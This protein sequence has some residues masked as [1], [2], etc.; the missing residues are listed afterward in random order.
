M[1]AVLDARRRDLDRLAS[2][3]WELLVVGGGITGSGIALDAASRG[4]RTALVEREDHAVGT[5]GRSSR[6]IHGGLRYLEQLRIGLVREA[7]AERRRLLRLA[8]HLV[9]IE[10]FV[11]PLYGGPLTRPF[12]EA[13]LTLYDLLGAAADGGWH[14]HL[15]VDEALETTPVLRRQRL[16]G[17]LVYHDGQEDD[18]RYTLAVART[19]RVRGAVPVTRLT[20][21][22]AIEAGGRIAGVTVR[23]ELGG[24]EFDV[25]AERVVDATGVWSGRPEGPFPWTGSGPAVRPSRGTHIVVPRDRIPSAHGLTLRIPGR[26][27]FLVPWPDRWVIGTTDIDDD[28]PP[29]HPVPSAAEVDAILTNVNATLDID[30]DR[31]DVVGAYTGLRPLASDPGGHPGSTV[32]A[33]REHRIRTDPNGLVRI[34]GGKYTTYRLMAA[35]TVDVAV[36][37]ELAA[38]RPSQTAELPL[39][40]AAPIAE[41]DAL[42]ARLTSEADLDPDRAARLVARH[43]TE[44][45]AVVALG[46]ELDLLRPLGP[47][48]AHLEVEAVWAVR[49]EVALSLDDVLSRRTRLSQELAD[50][51]AA[52]APRVAELI[53]PELGWSEAD[54]APA[55]EA[56][57]ASAHTEYDVP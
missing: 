13:G 31:S 10:P 47:D 25:L 34:G 38:Q 54:R 55:V 5:S 24:N 15:S 35:Q 18:A 51:G 44:A 39:V 20:A 2:E 57:L 4:L 22:R 8:P 48:I 50:R 17:A 36:G 41:L 16:R 26:V 46:R 49:T 30:L 32:K 12:Y 21:V 3:T 28:G 56:Y 27:C 43:G 19:A 9:R 11:F 29:D 52:I 45:S 42:T 14:R 1:T 40:G 33:S 6:L 23:D 53:G 37:P 7:L